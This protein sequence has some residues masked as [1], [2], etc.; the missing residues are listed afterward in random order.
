MVLR[1]QYSGSARLG[2]ATCAGNRLSN[3]KSVAFRWWFNKFISYFF[4]RLTTDLDEKTKRP[5]DDN[6]PK[7]IHGQAIERT[8]DA[9]LASTAIIIIICNWVPNNWVGGR[10]NNDGKKKNCYASH[11]TRI[12]KK[13]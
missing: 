8:R 10:E 9:L 6:L 13:R 1:E 3:P 7:T 2:G 5:T 4:C 12:K 11:A